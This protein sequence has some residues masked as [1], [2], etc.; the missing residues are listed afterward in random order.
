[1]LPAMATRFPEFISRLSAADFAVIAINA[2]STLSPLP[3][4]V[5]THTLGVKRDCRLYDRR[6]LDGSS[7]RSTGAAVLMDVG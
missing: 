7:S 5:I 1:M 3:I 2:R 6:F 4:G